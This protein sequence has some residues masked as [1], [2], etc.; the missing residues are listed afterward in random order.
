MDIKTK[1][2][3]LKSDIPDII[4]DIKTTNRILIVGSHMPIS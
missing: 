3:N 1:A 2:K 4:G